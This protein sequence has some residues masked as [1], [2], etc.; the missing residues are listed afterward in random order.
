MVS[1]S[2][3]TLFPVLALG[4]SAAQ[5]QFGQSSDLYD[6]LGNLSPYHAAPAVAGV[7][8]SLPDDCTV[9]QVMLVSRIDYIF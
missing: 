6:G 2:F 5:L 1:S 4:V 7:R 9:N 3:L 8:S